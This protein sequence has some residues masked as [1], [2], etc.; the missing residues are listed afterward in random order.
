MAWDASLH[1]TLDTLSIPVTANTTLVLE[2]Y[3][4]DGGPVRIKIGKQVTKANGSVNHA[5]LSGIDVTYAKQVAE[6]IIKLSE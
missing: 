6:A 3:S 2:K 1:K 4:Y 5:P